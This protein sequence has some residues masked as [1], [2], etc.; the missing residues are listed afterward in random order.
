M[1]ELVP[2]NLKSLELKLQ[3]MIPNLSCRAFTRSFA[4]PSA[5]DRSLD[6]RLQ[7]KVVRRK[8]VALSERDL[9]RAQVNRVRI[10]LPRPH[11]C[12]E[13]NN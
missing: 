7:T 3:R 9:D 4:D 1:E 5:Y 10:S 13:Y 12:A 11:C 6:L 2:W 8:I